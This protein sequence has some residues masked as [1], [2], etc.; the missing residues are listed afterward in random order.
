MKSTQ[1]SKNIREVLSPPLLKE[2]H[3]PPKKLFVLGEFPPEAPCVAIVGTRNPSNY[4]KEITQ[5]FASKLA[6]YGYAVVSGFAR[7]IDT[8]AHE[9]ALSVQGK[10]IAVFGCGLDFTFPPE[11]RGLRKKILEQKGAIISEFPLGTHPAKETFP[12]RNR[13]ISGLSIAT[14]IIEAPERSGALITA[15]FAL[16]QGREIFAI[17]G[18]LGQKNSVGCNELIKKGEAQLVASPE[19]LIGIISQQPLPFSLHHPT[20]EEKLPADEKRI[21]TI[22]QNGP[23]PFEDILQQTNFALPHLQASL[24]QLE[25]KCLISRDIHMIRL[26]AG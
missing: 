1:N 24:T 4:G 8:A 19:E 3:N 13:I 18:N 5:W 9:G 10:T 23:V 12:Q 15:R 7:G 26:R 16:E 25:L 17:P 22:L 2:I 6:Q 21:F 11:N 20:L 14:L